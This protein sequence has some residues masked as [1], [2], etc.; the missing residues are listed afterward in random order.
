[1]AGNAL[2]AAWCRY[3]LTLSHQLRSGLFTLLLS[4]LGVGVALAQD[5]LDRT[6]ENSD[7]QPEPQQAASNVVVVTAQRKEEK[8]ADVPMSLV[9]LGQESLDQQGLT[10]IDDATR[11]V[12]G[13][14][15]LRMGS[16]ETSDF[17]DEQSDISIR[18]VDSSAGPSTTGV[19][20]DDT[21]IS[22]RRLGPSPYPELFDLER[23]EVLKGPQGTLFGAGSEGGSIRF[24]TPEPGLSVYSGYTKAEFGQIEG[25]GQNYQAGGAFGG[26]ILD[27]VL[28]FRV[29]ASFREDG[30]WVDRVEY[31]SPPAVA[32]PCTGCVTT[33]AMVYAAAPTV[34]HITER[35]ANWHDTATARAALKWQAS[36]S[37][38]V[39]PSIYV[40]TLHINDTGAY[41]RNISVPADNTYYNG[42]QL[43]DPTTDP[44]WIAS[45]K[46]SWSLPSLMLTSNTSYFSRDQHSVS[47]YSQWVPTLFL[48]N[49]Y[50]G[51]GDPSYSTHTDSDRNFTQEVR[52]NSPG[53]RAAIQW[54]GGIFFSRALE[55][56][57]QTIVSRDLAPDASDYLAYIQPQ[58]SYLDRQFAAFAE[59]TAKLT[60]ALGFIAGLRYSKLGVESTLRYTTAGLLGIGSV[61][62][63]NSTSDRPI[64]PRFVFQYKPENG[65][66]Y[67]I[68]AAKGFRPGGVNVPLSQG[69]VDT[70]GTQTP[71][72][73]SSDSLWQYELGSKNS[74]MGRRVE[75]DASVYYLKWTNTQ[76]T[77][78]LPCGISFGANLGDVVSKGGDIS[79]TWRTTSALNISV[80]AAYTDA[81]FQNITSVS[82][83]S[84]GYSVVRNG[85]HLP[86]SPWNLDASAEYVWGG[87]THKPY[88]R[89]DY[90]YATAQR[91]LT[92]YLDP[93]NAPNADP[94]LSGL[95]EIRILTLRAGVRVDGCDISA[96]AQNALDYHTPIYDAR[97]DAT[98]LSNGVSPDFDNNFYGRGYPPRTYGVT[99]TYRF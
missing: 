26:P 30:G 69:L 70:C 64:T 56:G 80:V 72:T 87:V 94:E 96:Y 19:Y 88:L 2:P 71:S 59:V 35:N 25:G 16:S 46:G 24:I 86:A 53:D 15:F 81:V 41:W 99:M 11:V 63:T 34:T 20:I 47:D 48:S 77:V 66:M 98:T 91:S 37:L 95:P 42:N 89:A 14:T 13:V 10:N 82:G 40:Q 97:D 5:A 73:I 9:A 90:Q 3:K 79:V 92:P 83:F 1:M 7:S 33:P 67:Y 4:L 8:L 84:G 39:E 28:G 43:R 62:S 45:I 78:Y 61:N 54:T 76:Q 44:W 27:G 57:G 93:S 51:N 55:N 17:D 85:D 65:Q 49:E 68:S 12:P 18:G 58:N 52:V 22:T 21:P 36:D 29:S 75:I 60:D 50:G 38:T 74:L 23:V 6:D 32:V 31:A